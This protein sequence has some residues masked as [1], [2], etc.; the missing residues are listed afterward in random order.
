[1]KSGNAY[2]KSQM[3]PDFAAWLKLDIGKRLANIQRTDTELRFEIAQKCNEELETHEYDGTNEE[4]YAEASY[5]LKHAGVI[6]ISASGETLRRWMD[7]EKFYNGM[8]GLDVYMANLGMEHFRRARSLSL[9]EGIK[10][11]YVLDYAIENEC[12]ALEMEYNFSRQT[13]E[14]AWIRFVGWFRKV[15]QYRPNLDDEGMAKY[16]R[17]IHE[18]GELLEIE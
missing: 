8:T 4:F 18:L 6:N 11:I 17:L 5:Y 12:T 2:Q 3:R 7:I 10:A 14:R 15:A 9:N 13:Q 16:Q 1:M